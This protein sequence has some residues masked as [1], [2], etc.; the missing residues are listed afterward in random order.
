MPPAA[1]TSPFSAS[2]DRTGYGQTF[3]PGTAN[4]GEASRL[5]VAV[6]QEAQNI[7]IALSPVRTAKLSG[8][9][10][11]SNGKPARQGMVMIRERTNQMMMSVRPGI[12]LR[13]HLDDPWRGSRA[14]I[15]WSLS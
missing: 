1:R 9:V 12:V 4:P 3:Y 2:E 13:R 15:N 6:G 14:T 5:T 11:S 7:V 8:T 10:T